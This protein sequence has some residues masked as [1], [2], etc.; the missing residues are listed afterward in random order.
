VSENFWVNIDRH[1]AWHILNYI[2]S[3]EANREPSRAEVRL[4]D[5]GLTKLHDIAETPR[6][7]SKV[8]HTLPSYPTSQEGVG[9][10]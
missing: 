1:E 4:A 8:K 3:L 6:G 9:G 2:K 5:R 10:C 7:K